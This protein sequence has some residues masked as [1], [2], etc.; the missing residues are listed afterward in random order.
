ML[1]KN[2]Y[3]LSKVQQKLKTTG[4]FW[5]AFTGDSI[6]SCEWVHP[7]WREIVEYVLKDTAVVDGDWKIPS[8]GIRTFNFAYDGSTTTDVVNRLD[9][10]VSVGPDLIIS[11][12]GGNDPVL[13]VTV[14]ETKKNIST[15]KEMAHTEVVWCTTTP[16]ASFA[17]KDAVY[18]PYVKAALAVSETESFHVLDMYSL[19]REY[20]MDKFFTFKSEENP[21]EG[22]KA[23]DP[24]PD[25]P[26]QLGNAYIAK[27]ILDKVFGIAFDP[28]IYISDTVKGE[29]LP[30]F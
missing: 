15:I 12:M 7:N 27:I 16:A 5:L 18:E 1:T 8:W 29:K 4:K 23:G 9:E 17:N 30:R 14:E 11:L 19:Y 21:V 26:N 24:D 20:P 3:P 28:E 22:L 10:I 25:H 2:M 13:G 6:T